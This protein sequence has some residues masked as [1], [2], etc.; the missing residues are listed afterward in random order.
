MT[1]FRIEKIPFD[2]EI[3]GLWAS[4][5]NKHSN[6]PVVYTLNG[7]NEIYVGETSNAAMRF[8][9]HLNSESKNHL[10]DARVIFRDDFNK[11]A[12]LDLES[13][14]IKLFAADEKYKVLNGNAGITDSDYFQRD[15]YRE[16]FSEIFN[17]L[18]NDGVLTRTVPDIV[19]SDLFKYS[20][21]KALN[22]D[23]AIA[24]EG[25]LE[26]LANQV[27]AGVSSKTVVEGEP[28]TGKTIV[29]IYLMKLIRDI[30]LFYENDSFDS[31]NLFSDFF[32]PGFKEIFANLKIGLVI[33]QISLRKTVSKVFSRT[34]GLEPKMVL[35]PFEVGESDEIFDLLIVDESHRLQQRANQPAAER[36]IKYATINQKLFGSDD[37]SKTQLDWITNRSR[38]QIF[39]LDSAQS[40]KPADLQAKHISPLL[41]ES[42]KNRTH[43]KLSSQMRVSGGSDYIEFIGQILN[44]KYDETPKNFGDYELRFF[45][46]FHD[47]KEEIDLREREFGLSRLL[48][49]FAWPWQSKGGKIDFDI[50]IEGIRLP[51]NR[52][53][54]DWVSSPTSSDEVGSIH[55]IQGYDLNFAGVIIGRD[56]FFDKNEKK[57]KF[58]RENY[59][60]KKGKENNPTLGIKYSDDDL[61]TYVLSIYRVLLTRGIRG[62]FVYICDE[63]L[64]S[65]LRQFFPAVGK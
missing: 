36:N 15:K 35:D 1:D 58:S 62:T 49:G 8:S 30:A 10:S 56:L 4:E 34:P 11:S 63:S 37:K 57:I 3:I 2:R 41:Q 38:H 27:E 6:W 44:G 40:V 64:R 48:A 61:L 17:A 7:S 16:T 26:V 20:P 29:A 18:V 53:N 22:T 19:N 25:I 33:P 50:E 46:S 31:D 45:D 42:R 28:G 12:C 9:N 32:Q 52:R 43:F 54:Y 51:W 55:T 24:I 5:Q 39:L 59:F 60:D 47:M 65:H 14:L 21:F 13:H 23:Q